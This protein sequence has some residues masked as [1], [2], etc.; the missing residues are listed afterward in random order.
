MFGLSSEVAIYLIGLM[1][2]FIT[3]L[4]TLC[5]MYEVEIGDEDF[6]FACGMVL[7]AS[8]IWPLVLPLTLLV[9]ISAG[10]ITLIRKFK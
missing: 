9:G 4:T 6:Y 2:N 3:L 1:F 10:L 7:L 8:V 5:L